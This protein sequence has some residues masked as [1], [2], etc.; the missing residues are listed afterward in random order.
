MGEILPDDLYDAFFL[1]QE[2]QSRGIHHPDSCSRISGFSSRRVVCVFS[3]YL[4][5]VSRAAVEGQ[6]RLLYQ[7]GASAE[8]LTCGRG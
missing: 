7:Q 5:K 2:E 1:R 4:I 6:R 8:P 3:M